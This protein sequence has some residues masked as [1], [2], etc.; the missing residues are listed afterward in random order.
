MSYLTKIINRDRELGYV[1]VC[2]TSSDPRTLPSHYNVHLMKDGTF[3]CHESWGRKRR[4]AK[5]CYELRAALESAAKS[6][7]APIINGVEQ[8][9]L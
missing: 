6:A 9:T 1:E 8:A 2:A 7:L 5:R 4:V 3:V